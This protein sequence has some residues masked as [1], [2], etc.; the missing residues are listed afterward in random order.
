MW[1]FSID[2]K[3][4]ATFGTT[5]RGHLKLMHGGF[6]FVKNYTNKKGG[7]LWECLKSRRFKCKGKAQ[8]RRINGRE[9]VKLYDV[10]IHLPMNQDI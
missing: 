5:Q 3:D 2:F 7:I 10:H 9:M 4:E 6:E 8:T 1:Y